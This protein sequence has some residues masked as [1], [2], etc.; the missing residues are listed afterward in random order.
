MAG[1]YEFH[2]SVLNSIEFGDR[3]LILKIEAYRQMWRDGYDINDG[4]GSTQSIEI[5]VHEPVVEYAFSSFP[6]ELGD[7]SLK[8]EK[9]VA[10]PSDVVGDLIPASLK[11]SI[12]VEIC[13]EGREELTGEYKGMRIRRVSAAITNKGEVEF[14]EE[15]VGTKRVDRFFGKSKML[16]VGAFDS[17]ITDLASNKDH[18]RDFGLKSM[19]N[20]SKAR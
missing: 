5:T 14:V 15:L 2:D 19:G 12:S 18:L 8:A 9:L 6:V 20:R 4:T 7:G 13:L 16:G 10:D 3:Q 11:H 17:G 1:F